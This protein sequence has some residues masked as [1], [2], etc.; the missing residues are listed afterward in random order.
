MDTS[1]HPSDS[2]SSGTATG[3]APGAG[4]EIVD[5]E[6]ALQAQDIAGE[7]FEAAL[8]QALEL[9]GGHLLF[10][11]PEPP[12]PGCRRIA[13]VSLGSGEERVLALVVLPDGETQPLVEAAGDSRHPLARIVPTYADVM[14]LIGTCGQSDQGPPSS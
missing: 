13:A 8:A 9:V 14:A 6:L 11:M 10:D 3:E 1:P 12:E 7:G 5:L 2:P 4:L